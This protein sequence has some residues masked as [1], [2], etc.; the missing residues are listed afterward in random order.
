M[1]DPS[2][3]SQAESF[4]LVV[5]STIAA[6]V[7]LSVAGLFTSADAYWAAIATIIVL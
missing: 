1:P 6:L 5:G 4:E 2:T 3:A 7:A